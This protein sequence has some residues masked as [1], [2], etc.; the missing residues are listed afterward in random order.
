MSLPAAGL[1]LAIV[2][3]LGFSFKAILVKLA[4]AVPSPQVLDALTLLALRMLYS[5][6]VFVWIAWR[7]AQRSAPLNARQFGMIALLGV[8]GYYASSLLDF[9]GLQYISAGLERLVLSIY[10]TLTLLLAVLFLGETLTRRKLLAC[11]LCYF[12]LAAAFIHDLQFSADS[13][14]VWIGSAFVFASAVTYALY[15]VGNGRMVAT[16]GSQRFAALAALVS[17]AVTLMHFAVTRAPVALLQPLQTHGL[18]MAMALFSTVIPVLALSAAIR[19]I[20]APTTALIGSSGP[21]LTILLA[22]LLLG[23]PVSLIQLGGMVLVT[24]GVLLISRR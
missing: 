10:P 17:A 12:G 20:G 2:A 4:Y 11:A 18:A 5:A 21:M 23:E 6:P 8:L 19:R 24:L 14:A 15:L 22:W 3:A 7:E 1:G 16:V 13:R 9:I